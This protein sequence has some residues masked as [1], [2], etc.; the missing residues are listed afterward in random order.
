VLLDSDS[1]GGLLVFIVVLLYLSFAIVCPV[2]LLV[3]KRAYRRSIWTPLNGKAKGFEPSLM[4][5]VTKEEGAV[6][7]GL[8]GLQL[9]GGLGDYWTW[10]VEQVGE[11][12]QVIGS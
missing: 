2:W 11:G 8:V 3:F 7:A 10:I 6:S 5:A 1:L 4:A 12:I 9:L